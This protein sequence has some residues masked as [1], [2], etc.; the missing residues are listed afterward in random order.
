PPGR[1]IGHVD[2]FASRPPPAGRRHRRPRAPRHGRLPLARRVG[3]GA[4]EVLSP[5]GPGAGRGVQGNPH[6]PAGGDE[7]ARAAHHPV[8]LRRGVAGQGGARR[9]GGHQPAHQG[10]DAQP[11][12]AVRRHAGRGGLRADGRRHPQGNSRRAGPLRPARARVH[13]AGRR[14]PGPRRAGAALLR[15]ARP[16][17][18]AAR[19]HQAAVLSAHHRQQL[20]G[21]HAGAQ[22]L[23]ARGRLHHRGAHGRRPQRPAPRRAGAERARRAPVRRPRRGRPGKDE[24]PGPTLLAGGERGLAG[25][26]GRGAGR[27]RGGHP[28]GH[29]VRLLR[30]VGDHRRA[31][32]QRHPPG[33]GRPHRRADRRP[34]VAHGLSLQG[35]ADRRDAF[36]PRHV[37]RAQAGVRPGLPARGVQAPR[38]PP[39]LPLRRRAGG[40]LRQE[41][42]RPGKHRRAQVP[43]QR[44]VRGDRQGAAALGRLRGE[45]A[46]HQRRRAEEPAPLHWRRPRRLHGRR[47][48]RLPAERHQEHD[49][50]PAALAR[51]GG[52][53]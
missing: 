48:D 40:H 23:G 19:G 7:G 47:G 33:A 35:G 14:G 46:D 25:E 6:V 20:A 42:R 3:R 8:R 43:V 29:P 50:Q 18:A 30:R 51:G 9:R 17:G 26:A 24:G 38:R 27:G 34:R 52:S 13:E 22:G 32:A 36:A 39:G 21:D 15:P 41:G 5:R 1:R 10:A 11:G 53:L 4:D 16:F 49:A 2:R 28:G 37:R 45:A 12:H 44:A 31:Q